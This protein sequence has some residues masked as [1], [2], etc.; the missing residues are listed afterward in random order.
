MKFRIGSYLMM[1]AGVTMLFSACGGDGGGGGGSTP[2]TVTALRNPVLVNTST[3]IVASFANY[4]STVKFGSTVNFTVSSPPATF[5]NVSSAITTRAVTTQAGGL[6]WVTVKSPLPGK[7]TVS[8]SSGSFAGSTTVAFINQ[9]YIVQV[10]AG[11][12]KPITNLGELSLKIVNDLPA[13]TF[14]NFSSSVA[15]ANVT[16]VPLPPAAGVTSTSVTLTA[17]PGV[18]VAAGTMFR[19]NYLIVDPGVPIFT[20]PLSDLSAYLDDAFFTPVTPDVSFSVTY[21][22]SVG[23]KLYP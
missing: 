7:F 22:D 3:T 11:L 13:P 10:L 12:N 8:A 15:G 5:S 2:I 18:N 4:T 9:P 6:A 14:L 19:L 17:V 20:L 21:F 16:T 23:T 1:L